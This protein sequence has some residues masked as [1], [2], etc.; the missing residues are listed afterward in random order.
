MLNQFLTREGFQFEIRQARLIYVG[1]GPLAGVLLERYDYFQMLF[2]WFQAEYPLPAERSDVFLTQR[3][4]QLL[5]AEALQ[6][7]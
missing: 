4:A 7:V 3:F 1:P 6:A 5:G 2:G